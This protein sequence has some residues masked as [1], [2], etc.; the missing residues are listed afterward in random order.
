MQSTAPFD[1]ATCMYYT[2]LDPFTKQEVYVA[3]QLRDRKAQ[4]ALM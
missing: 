2:G 4:R 3:R 1:I